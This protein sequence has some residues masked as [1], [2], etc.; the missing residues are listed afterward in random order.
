MFNSSDFRKWRRL[1]PTTNEFVPIDTALQSRGH[2]GKATIRPGDE[3]AIELSLRSHPW[4]G[5]QG[6]IC[7]CF[8]FIISRMTNHQSFSFLFRLCQP[9]NNCS[10]FIEY[11]VPAL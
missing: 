3:S 8:A 5:L 1:I 11:L 7:V 4:L 10:K 6:W 9:R 2:S